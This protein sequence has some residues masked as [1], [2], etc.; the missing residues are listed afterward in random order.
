VWQFSGA[1]QW[2]AL[3][4]PF[5][6]FGTPRRTDAYPLLKRGSRSDLVV[7]AQQHLM[8]AGLLSILNGD[9]GAGTQKA[10]TAFQGSRGLPATG[11]LDAATWAALL[12]IGPAAIKWGL[13]RGAVQVVAA[14]SHSHATAQ[15]V[16]LNAHR[17]AV[18][19]ELRGVPG[20]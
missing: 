14:R 15:P 7:W 11:R 10:V 3:G 19:D 16:P 12:P 17:P 8:K 1:R 18:R 6:P 5:A 13:K 2:T 4:S 20:R 9:Y